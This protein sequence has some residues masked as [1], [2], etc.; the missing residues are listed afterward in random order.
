MP[1]IF[2][3]AAIDLAISSQDLSVKKF[4]NAA[5]DILRAA[6][7]VLTHDAVCVHRATVALID[8]G[9]SGPAAALFRTLMD[10][11][12][13]S[14]A[15]GNSKNPRLAAFRYLYAGLRRQAR[16]E[17]LPAKARRQMF[18][19]IRQRLRTLPSELREQAIQVIKDRDR[20]YWFAPE[21]P[22]PSGVIAE[23]GRDDLKWTYM[24]ASAAAHGTFLGMRL[25]RD[26][27]DDI[28]INPRP[29]GPRAFSLDL[30][31]C[32]WLI[33]IVRVRDTVERLGLAANINA[34]V[35]RI[36]GAVSDLTKATHP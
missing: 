5:E 14:I 13:S 31:S 27:P 30:A 2:Y 35:N 7:F 32:R 11:S 3:E 26:N 18:D 34:L 22:S 23:F 1:T 6:F 29:L 20:P 36:A 28:D 8:A 24:Q 17:A 9:W 21:W 10:L 19:Q 16:D 25:F 33:E 15:L 12:V 4:G